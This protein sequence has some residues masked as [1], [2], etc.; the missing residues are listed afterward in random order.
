MPVRGC[1]PVGS[2]QVNL[3]PKSLNTDLQRCH[4]IRFI[5]QDIWKYM[6]LPEETARICSNE[7]HAILV[8]PV[9]DLQLFA[10]RNISKDNN[11]LGCELLR[12]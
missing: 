8:C 7:M 11:L 5:K 6:H 4:I 3:G 1:S 10:Q 9:V 2:T 12:D